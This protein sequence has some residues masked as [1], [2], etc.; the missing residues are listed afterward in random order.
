MAERLRPGVW[1]VQ[2][3]VLT[4]P[5]TIPSARLTAA[6]FRAPLSGARDV[7][8][9]TPLRPLRLGGRALSLLMCLH[10]DEWA[11][12]SYDEVGVGLLAVGPR[13]RPGLYLAD[14]P[15]TGA[16]TREAGQDLWGLPKW[17]MEC[18]LRFGA[19]ATSVA[20]RGVFDGTLRH[21]GVR[22]PGVRTSLPAWSYLDHGAQAGRLL[23]GRVPM[24][25]SGVRLGRSCS[26]ELGSHP[27]AER[28]RGLG[29]LGRP[30]FTVHAERLRGPLG[31]YTPVS[32]QP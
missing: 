8:A 1:A 31:E 32:R 13:G 11:L 4:L 29:M 25:L 21:P 14:L 5:V 7:L 3:S 17:L 6:V 16:F 30:L 19:T 22:L 9:A 12:H 24:R 10:Y 27:M 23:R 18:D 20:V 28:M 26:I 2:G 15:V